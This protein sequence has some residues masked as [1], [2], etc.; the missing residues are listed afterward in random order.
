MCYKKNI[1][2]FS[3]PYFAI[4]FYFMSSEIFQLDENKNNNNPQNKFE[5]DWIYPTAGKDFV[6]M[7]A[8]LGF[9]FPGLG[10]IYIGQLAKGLVHIFATIFLHVICLLLAPILV[11]LILYPFALVYM[12]FIFL[13]GIKVADR[14]KNGYPVMK[15]ECYYSI[16][17]WGVGAFVKPIFNATNVNNCPQVWKDKMAKYPALNN[18]PISLLKQ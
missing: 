10:T 4:D 5:D 16:A 2:E 6:P 9:L 13:D 15:G 18:I 17:T 8:L 7:T 11:G 1:S 3:N 12:L 14:L